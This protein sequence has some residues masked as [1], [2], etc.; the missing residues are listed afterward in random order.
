MLLNSGVGV[1]KEN[2]LTVLHAID[3]L[4]KFSLIFVPERKRLHV[5]GKR[6]VEHKKSQSTRGSLFGFKC[7][8]INRSF[9]CSY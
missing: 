9:F 7:K 6:D 1:V 8:K 3:D 2:H 5:S 4:I